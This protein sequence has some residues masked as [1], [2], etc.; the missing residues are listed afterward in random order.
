MK[1]KHF[2]LPLFLFCFWPSFSQIDTVKTATYNKGK[3][4]QFL[5]SSLVPLALI[6][7]GV[8]V[9]YS[10]GSL[11]KESLQED[12]Q[13]GLDDFHTELDNFLPFVPALTMYSADL[14]HVTSRNDAFTQTKYLGIALL[15]NNLVT[16]GIKK[17]SDEERPNGDTYSFPSGHT[18]NAF[19]MATALHLEFK[20]SNILLA[21]SGYLFATATGVLRVMNNE[22]WVSDV[23]AGAGIGM[24]STKLVYHFEPLK[25]WQP[26]KKEGIK[27]TICPSLIDDTVGFYA[28]LRF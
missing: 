28:N 24:L 18:S 2:L 11:G 27:T 25:N 14:L 3:N 22:H 16:L 1:S 20:D 23:L 6:G 5:K 13:D 9:N 8:F 7:T 21:Y 15:V 4:Q 19:V 10:D 17:I 12:I 26:F